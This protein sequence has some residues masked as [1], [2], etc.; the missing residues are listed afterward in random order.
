MLLQYCIGKL[1]LCC[2]DTGWCNSPEVA[3]RTAVSPSTYVA[4]TLPSCEHDPSSEEFA[5]MTDATIMLY[6]WQL[7]SAALWWLQQYGNL[8]LVLVAMGVKPGSLRGP[9]FDLT[10]Q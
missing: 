9:H 1:V 8:G 7:Y 3:C 10:D 2:C 4:Y 6:R 5:L